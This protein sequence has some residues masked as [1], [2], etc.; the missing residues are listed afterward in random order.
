MKLIEL[1]VSEEF[2]MARLDQFL[3][4]HLTQSRT[5]IRWK[6]KCKGPF[7]LTPPSKIN[8]KGSNHLLIRVKPLLCDFSFN[9]FLK[10]LKIVS[11]SSHL[12]NLVFFLP[13]V[14][15]ESIN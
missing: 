5:Y 1:T 8:K 6:I 9:P 10:K 12:K 15:F 14:K 3:A 13:T 2:E 11:K 7:T 4:G